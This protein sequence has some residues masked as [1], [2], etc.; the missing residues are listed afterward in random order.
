[1]SKPTHTEASRQRIR[2]NE[3]I[4][5]IGRLLVAV[6][7]LTE[8]LLAPDRYPAD[9]QTQAAGLVVLLGIGGPLLFLAHRRLTTLRAQRRFGVIAYAFD[10][11]LALGVVLLFP[12]DPASSTS[13]ILILIALEAAVRFD[14]AG[15]LHAYALIALTVLA[16]Q[17]WMRPDADLSFEPWS[18]AFRMTAFA[19]VIVIVAGLRR[20][21][22][23]EREQ[24][25]AT[26]EQL[27][28]LEAWRERLTAVL[29]HDIRSPLA[30]V[31]GGIQ[32]LEERRHDLDDAVVDALLQAA[33]RQTRRVQVLARDLLDLARNDHDQLTLD[34]QTVDIVSLLEQVTAGLPVTLDIPDGLHASADPNRLEQILFNLVLNAMK[35]GAEPITLAA[36][37]RGDGLEIV[38]EDRGPGV[39]DERLATLF[40]AFSAGEVEPDSVG[41]G[42]WI[43]E[44]LTQAH[45]GTVAYQHAHPHGSRFTVRIPTA[46][47]P[48]VVP[49]TGSSLVTGVGL[50]DG[51]T[52]RV[53]V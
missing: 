45:G 6:W 36:R 21:L 39:P 32:V 47:T 44:V 48:Q 37:Q 2:R 30:T 40:E 8:W 14:L 26:V 20:N 34:T 51:G 18:V 9:V 49:A 29:A 33:A 25:Q 24:L 15:A 10:L 31:S 50:A 3:T 53:T 7:A 27:E 43:V 22:T 13:A 52:V 19:L 28:R 35:H 11:A 4:I 41:L 16:V 5:G 23:M 38:V 42:L 46:H 12:L 17:L 1:M